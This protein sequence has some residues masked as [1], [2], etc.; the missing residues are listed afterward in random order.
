[1]LIEAI[2]EPNRNFLID[3]L[4]NQEGIK[5]ELKRIYKEVEESKP[6]ILDLL[7]KINRAR[8]T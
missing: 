4:I 2:K 3:S 6:L 8:I 7:E 5:N 1:M